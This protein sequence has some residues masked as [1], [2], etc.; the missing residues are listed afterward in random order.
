MERVEHVEQCSVGHFWSVD[1]RAQLITWNIGSGM[2]IMMVINNNIVLINAQTKLH[3]K[4]MNSDSA[5]GLY[6]KYY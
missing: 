1:A 4:S 2:M 3:I 5:A 6:G